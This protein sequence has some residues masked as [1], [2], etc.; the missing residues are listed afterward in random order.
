MR[1]EEYCDVDACATR[2]TTPPHHGSTS[3][4]E[5]PGT[6][7][8]QHRLSYGHEGGDGTMRHEDNPILAL[9]A[10]RSALARRA[11][12]GV[13]YGGRRGS[14]MEDEVSVYAPVTKLHK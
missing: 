5:L 1:V 3:R 8:E 9:W 4:L 10:G 11:W 12:N 7:R 2:T 13:I 6:P 14:A